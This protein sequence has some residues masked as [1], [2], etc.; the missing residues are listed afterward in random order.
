MGVGGFIMEYEDNIYNNKSEGVSLVIDLNNAILSR[1]SSAIYNI[2][3]RYTYEMMN[4]KRVWDNQ[5]IA[6]IYELYSVIRISF[7]TDK[8]KENNEEKPT[9]TK[10][11]E[12][13]I[14]HDKIFIRKEI[15]EILELYSEL[16]LWLYHKGVTKFDT[17][18]KYD[19][20]RIEASNKH[21]GL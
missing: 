5:T 16:D 17:K 14:E 7:C 4:A 10:L 15:N 18:Q 13:I 9:Q 20:T 3:K 19:R 12:T 8:L 1:W 2:R 11:R 21:K 6:S